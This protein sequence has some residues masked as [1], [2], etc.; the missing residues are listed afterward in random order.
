MVKWQYKT[1]DWGELRKLGAIVTG[2]DFID[3]NVDA[4]LNKLGEEGWELV[5][6][7]VD[8]YVVHRSQKSIDVVSISRY[9]KYTFKRPVQD[10]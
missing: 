5:N 8:G 4:G 2:K 10:A 6:V 3:E 9:V 1:L 7:Y